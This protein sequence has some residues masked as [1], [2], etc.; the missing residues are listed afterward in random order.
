MPFVPTNLPPKVKRNVV[1]QLKGPKRKEQI[2]QLNS[3]LKKIAKKYG[4]QFKRR[5]KS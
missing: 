1:I 2:K 5:P 3:E 4:A